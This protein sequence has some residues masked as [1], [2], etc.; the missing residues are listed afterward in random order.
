MRRMKIA[1]GL[2]V[3]LGGCSSGAYNMGTLDSRTADL[4]YCHRVIEPI[5][6]SDPGRPAQ[7]NSGDYISYS[8]P[9]EGPSR[10]E[11]IRDQRRLEQFRF[12]RD[13][14]DQ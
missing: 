6:P 13:Y 2:A 14:I 12:G 10:E 3:L 11:M 4:D 5:G 1:L 9:C 8:G 7:D